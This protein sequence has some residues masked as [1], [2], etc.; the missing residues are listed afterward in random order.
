MIPL[1]AVHFRKIF[2]SHTLKGLPFIKGFF[3][4]QRSSPIFY[5]AKSA[6]AAMTLNDMPT[7]SDLYK[8]GKL[9]PSSTYSSKE[10]SATINA[11][12][13]LLRTDITSLRVT[14]IVN[15]ANSSL[16]GGGGVVG[17]ELS[18]SSPISFASSHISYARMEPSIVLPAL[19]F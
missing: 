17:F 1:E 18:T 7:L 14:A 13:S 2:P 11:K 10:P 19:S 12:I 9:Q 5:R 16:R 15:A 8:E 4:I 6:M 3:I